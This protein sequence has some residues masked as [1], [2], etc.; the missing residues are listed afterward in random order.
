[1]GGEW[2]GSEGVSWV[3]GEWE[4]ERFGSTYIIYI[5]YVFLRRWEAREL[6]RAIYY[7]VQK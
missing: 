6:R 7:C 3:G 1:M 5:R 2:E 4:W